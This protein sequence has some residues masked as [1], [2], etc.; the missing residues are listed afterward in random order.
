M[1]RTVGLILALLIGACGARHAPEQAVENPYLRQA[2]SL[3]RAGM[4]AMWRERWA[5]AAD[6]FGRALKAA[7][8]TADER[9]AAREWY[10]LGS[11]HAAMG[12]VD[13]AAEDFRQAERLARELNDAEHAMRARLA[14]ALL[15]ASDD[16]HPANVPAGFGPDVHL[17]AA[18][19]AERQGRTQVAQEEYGRVLKRADQ[20]RTGLLYRGRAQ[21]GLARLAR[22]G[23][24]A[25]LARR[26]ADAAVALFRQ[27]GAPRFIAHA[28]LLSATLP[29][30]DA[31][32][33]RQA[34]KAWL[35]Y[36]AL[37][38]AKG[39][40]Q[41]LTLLV[42]LAER[43]GDAAAAKQWRAR[44]EMLDRQATGQPAG[45]ESHDDRKERDAQGQGS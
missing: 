37:E 19:L 10:N 40:R 44:L 43:T 26:H 36:Q 24:D 32:R 1:K 38:D 4:D 17:A 2:Q 30:D 23:G 20:S 35:I 41:T 25:A 28:L 34:R 13:E 6:E 16:W 15:S 18:R 12:R 5:H 33:Q 11:A 7:Q 3:S 29:G 22:A 27:V 45:R 31:L 9:L 42:R 39:Q 21:L 14:R 8:L